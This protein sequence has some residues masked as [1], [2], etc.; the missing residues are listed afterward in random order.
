MSRL[1]IIPDIHHLVSRVDRILKSESYDKVIFL[2]DFFDSYDD[3]FTEGAIET[4]HFLLQHVIYNPKSIILWGNHCTHYL[5]NNPKTQCSGY[6][7]AKHQAIKVFIKP[8]HIKKWQWF[9]YEDGVFLSHAGL[10]QG[11]IP[12]FI[13][14]DNGIN[15]PDLLEFLTCE[16]KEADKT[17]FNGLSKLHWFM[18]AGRLR[19]GYSPFGGLV[20]QDI[21]E[22]VHINGLTQIFGHTYCNPPKIITE[23]A[24]NGKEL[25]KG[26]VVFGDGKSSCVLDSHL[27]HYAILENGKLT[28]KKYADL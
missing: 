20:W 28:I 6:T 18:S 9:H 16:A 1:L 12:H 7:K 15:I 27:N 21:N 17:L 10:H 23:Y 24:S 3:K 13:K 26:E 11:Y 5:G 2:G 14:Q 25:D 8:E 22:F 19:G 4:C